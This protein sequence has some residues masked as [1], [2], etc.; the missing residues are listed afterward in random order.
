MHTLASARNT[1][2][3]TALEAIAAV[4]WTSFT[5]PTP[6]LIKFGARI[7]VVTGCAVR[8]LHQIARAL[9]RL[10][11]HDTDAHDAGVLDLWTV[12]ITLA[13]ILCG[14]VCVCVCVCVFR[15][16]QRKELIQTYLE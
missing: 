9:A 1:F 7:R 13:A 6:A 15:A 11:V 12:L 14:M 8:L 3:S 16:M 5:V 10:G 4:L 2:I